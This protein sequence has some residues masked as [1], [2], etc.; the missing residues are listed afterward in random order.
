M[1]KLSRTLNKALVLILLTSCTLFRKKDN[2]SIGE[3]K[4]GSGIVINTEKSNQV[5]GPS[6]GLP[7]DKN[8]EKRKRNPVVAHA[9]SPG[10]YATWSHVG[11]LKRLR[12]KKVPINMLIGSE[13]GALTAALYAKH[14]K[15]SLVEWKMFSLIQ[16]LGKSSKVFSK[17][18]KST[19]N[20]FIDQEFKRDKIERF[21]IPLI[22]PLYSKKIDK[23][24]YVKRGSASTILKAHFQIYGESDL[25]FIPNSDLVLYSSDAIKES[26]ADIIIGYEVIPEQVLFNKDDGYYY[27]V[28]NN[29]RSR[30]QEEF[31]YFDHVISMQMNETKLDDFRRSSQL[32]S[33]GEK[34]VK[35]EYSILETILENWEEENND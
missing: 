31:S 1:M 32:I 34:V 27:G 22:L 24:V 14:K 8:L 18:W 20:D 33:Q 9:F 5:Y 3:V 16:K 19:I 35:E 17:D 13:F 15:T 30:I 28:Y 25:S 7:A 23:V 4:N 29:L 10:L 26:G 21:K 12:K 2:I 11:A 6:F